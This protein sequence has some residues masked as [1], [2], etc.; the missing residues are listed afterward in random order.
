MLAA[1]Q[2][3]QHGSGIDR[4]RG[5]TE[6]L[7]VDDDD[8]VGRDDDRAG[9]SARN[10]RRL[11]ARQPLGVFARSLPSLEALIDVGGTHFM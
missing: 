8:G 2:E 1:A 9:S 3:R 11:L 4:V 5:L 10:D 7:P 6:D